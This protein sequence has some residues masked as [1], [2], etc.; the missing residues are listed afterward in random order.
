MNFLDHVESTQLKDEPDVLLTGI[1]I[2][3][4]ATKGVRGIISIA[5]G[6]KV[7]KTNFML[8]TYYAGL[9]L[10]NRSKYKL[11]FIYYSFEMPQY[12]IEAQLTSFFIYN[13]SGITVPPS[14]ILGEEIKDDKIVKLTQEELDLV[15][16]YYNEYTKLLMEDTL[17]IVNRDNPTGI[18][19]TVENYMKQFGVVHEKEYFIGSERRTKFDYFELNDPLIR[20]VCI[21][22]HI[23]QINK[24]LDLNNKGVIDKMLS[25]EVELTNS[26]KVNFVNIIHM[27]RDLSNVEMMKLQKDRLHPTSDMTKDSGNI[28]ED[29]HQLITLMNPCDPKYGLSFHFGVNLNNYISQKINYR[30]FHLVENR[31]GPTL[32]LGFTV[33]FDTLSW[34]QVNIKA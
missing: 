9:W 2:L 23:R 5:A 6:P 8:F 18:K 28:A 15:K 7:G 21:I 19:K 10:K 24:E 30:T 13:F 34:S 12:D 26:Y 3:D 4:E 25:Y 16:K 32:H 22:D 33:N 31:R 14:R 11:K 29:S 1:K 17:F 20:V 27:N